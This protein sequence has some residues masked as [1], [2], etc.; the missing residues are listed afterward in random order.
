MKRDKKATSPDES[1]RTAGDELRATLRECAKL[2]PFLIGMSFFFNLFFLVSPLYTMQLFDRV[3]SSGRV[4]T[5]VL[6]TLIAA[7]AV[8]FMGGLDAIRSMILSRMSSWLERRLASR[9][10]MWSIQGKLLGIGQSTQPLRDLATIR[11]FLGNPG[12]NAAGDVPWAPVYIAVVWLIHPYLGLLGLAAA[13]SLFS[14]AVINELTSRKAFRDATKTVNSCQLSAELAIRNADVFQAM[15][16]LPTFITTWSAHNNSALAQ[17]QRASD[18]NSV[19]VGMSKFV[20]MLIQILIMGLG[21]YLALDNQI[22]GGAIIAASMLLARAL[23]PVEQSI[24]TWRFLM[25]ARDAYDRLLRVLDRIPEPKHSTRLPAMRGS[26]MCERLSYVPPGRPEPTLQGIHFRVE[27][28][29]VLGIIGPSGCGKSTLCRMMVGLI[30]PT[31]GCV[32]LDSADVAI[33]PRDQLGESIGYLPQDVELIEGTVRTNIARLL[34]NPDPQDVIEAAITAGVHEMILRLPQ[35]YETE[36]GEGGALLSGGQRQ[37]IGLARALYGRPRF[38][39][40]DEP[41]A[42]LDSEGEAALIRAIAAA[43]GWGATVVIIAHQPHILKPADKL[44]VLRLGRM[45]MFGPRDEVLSN[46]RVLR[47]GPAGAAAPPAQIGMP[48]PAEQEAPSKAYPELAN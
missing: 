19:L 12:A 21:A 46:L 18:W 2:I 15:S 22:S 39:V 1:D 24:G 41:N 31:K 25:S 32:R 4:E 27:G 5:L 37:R 35:G 9:V 8:L 36:I 16:L 47:G 20:R 42:S 26:L 11:A 10:L 14:I 33:W 23:A 3:L 13:V 44:L 38:I 17:Q 28:G 45:E 29:E 7:V 43:K 40:L 30:K 34:P 48:G 6:L